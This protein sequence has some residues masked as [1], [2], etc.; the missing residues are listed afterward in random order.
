MASRARALPLK[1]FNAAKAFP[2][3]CRAIFLD[4]SIP[5]IDG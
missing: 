2:V 5:T 1:I 4:F 3:S